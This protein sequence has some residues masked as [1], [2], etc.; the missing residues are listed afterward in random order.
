MSIE[1]S[2]Q[3]ELRDINR[4]RLEDL[5]DTPKGVLFHDID[6][7]I[8]GSDSRQNR[9]ILRLLARHIERGIF[10][11][12][13]TGRGEL[14]HTEYS[15][16]LEEFLKGKVNLN[17][18]PSFICTFNAALIQHTFSRD[19][20]YDI[21]ID[22]DLYD[23]I[24]NNELVQAVQRLNMGKNRRSNHQ[25]EVLI[26]EGMIDPRSLENPGIRHNW[27]QKLGKRYQLSCVYNPSW[28]QDNPDKINPLDIEILQHYCDG[29]IPTSP[30]ELAP[31]IKNALYEE[32]TSVSTN[33]ALGF[34]VIDIARPE[35]SK[36]LAFEKLYP[37]MTAYLQ[38]DDSDIQTIRE[39][40]VAGGDS[41]LYNDAPL[42]TMFK[43]AVTN[44]HSYWAEYTE[45][46]PV[47]LDF[48]GIDGNEISQTE[49]FFKH[50][51]RIV[52]E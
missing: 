32:G 1:R 47:I 6:G 7:F 3:P 39:N 43:D 27:S 10:T 30:A 48:P 37:F 31:Y 24:M 8:Y 18:Q 16:P 15:D 13:V 50:F 4:M 14:A 45:Y 26:E 42:M 28:I 19:I 11:A 36:Q 49:E 25:T 34:N 38:T 35:V 21:P 9:R 33:T 40:G 22:D 52:I 2:R 51:N 29:V 12:A 41:P 23:A 44:N 17:I 20:I 5:L 46:G